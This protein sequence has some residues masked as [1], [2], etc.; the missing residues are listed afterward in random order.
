MAWTK[1]AR[2]KSLAVRTRPPEERFW[3]K[4]DRRGDDECWPWR[5]A[6]NRKG[7]G[8]LGITR[9]QNVLAHRFSYELRFGPIPSGKLVLHDC[10]NPW[11]V[12]PAHLRAGT[13]KQNSGDMVA[14]GRAYSGE[15]HAWTKLSTEAVNRM[16]DRLATS[17]RPGKRTKTISPDSYAAIGREFG[18]SEATVRDIAHGRQRKYG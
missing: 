6:K 14:R 8:V 9:D 12:N 15:R 4:V 17:T 1:K 5:S 10:D 7:Y 18:V 11:C 2:E 16:R 3:S 13:P